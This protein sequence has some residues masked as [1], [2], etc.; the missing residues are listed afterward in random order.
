MDVELPLAIEQAFRTHQPY[1]SR[2]R[3]LHAVKATSV[4]GLLATSLVVTVSTGCDAVINQQDV[5]PQVEAIL[6][7]S[8][9]PCDVS[10]TFEG[11]GEGDADNAYA[12]I[13]LKAVG[14][15]GQGNVDV[16]TLM[17]RS[18]GGWDVEPKGAYALRSKA[19]T[20][21]TGVQE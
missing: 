17:T 9:I 8:Q 1:A 18:R 7:Q 6:A 12:M 4:F 11:V 21:C 3:G 5:V 20:L 16:E 15:P 10:V 14:A 13:R 2:I 19:T